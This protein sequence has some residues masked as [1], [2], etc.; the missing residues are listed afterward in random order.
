MIAPFSDP[1]AHVI[2]AAAA[3]PPGPALAVALARAGA[4]VVALDPDADAL[5]A[6][7]THV[8][9]RIETLT[10]DPSDRTALARLSGAWGDTHIDLVINLMPLNLPVDINAQMRGL[11][12]LVRHSARGLIRGQG[13]FV[14][15]AARPTDALALMGQGLVA[16]LGA[17]TTAL[18][19]ALNPRGVRF[20]TVTVPSDAPEVAHDLLV[21]LAQTPR[22][23][24]RGGQHDLD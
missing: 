9:E 23:H 4:R 21:Q 19:T 11:T 10:L 1:P 12:V 5:G 3:R 7:A 13:G 16:A 17:G 20:Y 15:L 14:T 18:N 8:P 6:I 22:L 24:L 2:I